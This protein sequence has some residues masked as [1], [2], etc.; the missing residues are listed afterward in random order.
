MC[1][2]AHAYAEAFLI[3][4]F[5]PAFACGQRHAI[6]FER[7]F[8]AAYKQLY[9]LVLARHNLRVIDRKRRSRNA[10]FIAVACPIV[11]FGAVKQGFRWDAAFIQAYAAHAVLLNA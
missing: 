1:F 11:Q 2:A 10:I 9:N 5:D 8:Y 7:S 6:L 4:A 3:P